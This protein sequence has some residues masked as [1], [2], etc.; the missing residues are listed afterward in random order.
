MKKITLFVL[1]AVMAT[2]VSSC[3]KDDDNNSN[4]PSGGSSATKTEMITAKSWKVTG[5]T[6]G[7]QDFY[8]QMD[9]CDKDDLHT[10]KTDNTYIY[11]EGAS[12]CDPSDPQV[13]S[14]GTWKFTENETK[15]EYDGETATIK[16]LTSTKMVLEGDFLGSTAV[17][18][19]TAQ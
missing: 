9:A 14:T 10:F 5:L 16:E 12:K 7:G 6:V 4:N 2:L 15:I 3:K 17:T 18:T 19:F 11:D 1:V 13:I 8:S